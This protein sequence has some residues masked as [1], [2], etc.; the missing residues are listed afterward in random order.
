M[1]SLNPADASASAGFSFVSAV[2]V[3]VDAPPIARLAIGR[4]DSPLGAARLSGRTSGA[5]PDRRALPFQPW[6]QQW[7]LPCMI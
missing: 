4:V 3:K 7:A 1:T 5:Y 2:L 6:A